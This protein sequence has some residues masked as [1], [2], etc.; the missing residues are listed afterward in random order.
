IMDNGSSHTSKA[1]R[2]WIA[3]HPRF[4]VTCTPKHASW[5]NVIEQW[6]SILTRKLLRRGSFGSQEDLD[7]Q[8]TEFTI[9][10]NKTAHPWKWKYDAD[11]EHARYLQRHPEKASVTQAA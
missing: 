10:Y 2:A 11:T 7:N 9:G 1:T 3:A 4:A 5:L 6:F 8:I